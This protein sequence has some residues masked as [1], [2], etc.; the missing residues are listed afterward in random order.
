MKANGINIALISSIVVAI[1]LIV[2]IAFNMVKSN[3]TSEVSNDVDQN[4]TD[5]TTTTVT[6]TEDTSMEDTTLEVTTTEVSNETTV[7][8]S[9]DGV[10]SIYDEDKD[11]YVYVE[12][13]NGANVV[14][15]GSVVATQS[16]EQDDIE[17]NV[18][19]D[20]NGVHIEYSNDANINIQ[21]N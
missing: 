5:I 9:D 13:S 17:V 3:D 8:N 21:I 6:T 1:L 18:S 20:G 10:I 12:N 2:G 16:T 15:D 19:D 14:I 11:V 4:T 7:I